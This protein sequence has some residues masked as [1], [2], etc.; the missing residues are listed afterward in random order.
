MKLTAQVTLFS[1]VSFV[2]KL[3]FTK[4]LSV[5]IKSGVPLLEALVILKDQTKTAAF[6]KVLTKITDDVTNGQDL[7]KTLAKHPKV[8]DPFFLSLIEIGESSGSLEEN[9]NFLA[10]QLKKERALTKKV[11]GAFF[12]PMMVL[13]A[14]TVMGGFIAL[15]LLPQLLVFFEAFEIELPI[16][17]KILLAL[18][19]FMKNYGV[20]AFVALFLLLFLISF[21]LKIPSIK[22]T[23]HQL[24]LKIPLFGGLFKAVQLTRFSRNLSILLKGGVPLDQALKTTA[25]TLA[26]VWYKEKAIKVLK[27]VTKGSSM[28]DVLDKMKDDAFPGL[29]IKM[30][31]V[32]EKSGNLEETL[33]YLGDFY[34]DEIDTVTKN[35]T[36]V[37]EPILLLGAGLA[38][39]F[40]A[41]AV[42]SPIYELTGS[43]RR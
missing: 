24:V 5:M 34:E 10:I 28:A 23:W 41:L 18:A 22:K 37:L 6:R 19:I 36:V 25:N 32:G 8:F 4:H 20:F 42:I 33:T 43:F 15:Y 35:I 26:N 21:I 39:G 3:L 2:E 12:Y 13:L 30:I 11:Q 40:L 7:T 38:V 14:A 29:V 17:T 27:G 1:R 31:A 16:T 9:L